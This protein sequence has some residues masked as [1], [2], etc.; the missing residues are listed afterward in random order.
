MRVLPHRRT[1]LAGTAVLVVLSGCG[2][3]AVEQQPTSAAP[4]SL[5]IAVPGLPATLDPARA[6]TTTERAVAHAVHPPLLTSRRRADAGAGTLGPAL[7]RTLPELS[8]D[9]REYR[10]QLR[11]GLLYAD[12]RLVKA[13]DVERAIA[14]ASRTA[15]DRE[16]RTVLAGISGPPS[17]DGESLRGVRSDDRTGTLSVRLQAPDG[18][19]P[20]A[21]ASPATAPLPELPDAA[22]GAGQAT[23]GSLRVARSSSGRL[24]LV[25]NPLRAAIAEVPAAGATRVTLVPRRDAAPEADVWLAPAAG[26][27]PAGLRRIEGP[28]PAITSLLVAPRGELERRTTRRALAATLDRREVSGGVQPAAPACG[29]LPAFAVGAVVRDPCPQ[30]PSDPSR[31]PL[32]GMTLRVAV[33]SASGQ[34]V[35]TPVR[36][37]LVRLGAEVR[38]ITDADPAQAAGAGRAELAIVRAAPRL[39]HPAGWLQPVAAVDRLIARELPGRVAGPL[40]GTAAAWSAIERRAV[41]RA[42]ALPLAGSRLVVLIGAAVDRGSVRLHPVLGLELAALSRR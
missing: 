26:D 39:P 29:L 22:D 21:L 2:D 40:T 15:V 33:A 9:H 4:E 24:E 31:R 3:G 36:E 17:T 8:D 23:T 35:R 20:F 12:G 32:A 16:L 10:F 7:A 34:A 14:H 42:V 30:A 6:E 11:P 37:A 25:A 18:R 27:A 5:T 19:L 28:G 13:S 38:F 1:L 41:D